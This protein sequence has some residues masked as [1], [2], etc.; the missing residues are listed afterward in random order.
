MGYVIR[1]MT[2]TNAGEVPITLYHVHLMPEC[3]RVRASWSDR[4]DA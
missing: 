1:S 2:T 4:L 3:K